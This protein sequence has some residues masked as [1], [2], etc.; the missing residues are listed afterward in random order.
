MEDVG[1]STAASC[2]ASAAASDDGAWIAAALI[3]LFPLVPLVYGLLLLWTSRDGV[4]TAKGGTRASSKA[5]AKGG[6]VIWPVVGSFLELRR[7]YHRLEDWYLGFFSDDVKTWKLRIP[8]PLSQ[9]LIATVDPV[10]VEYILTNIHKYG[11]VRQYV[12]MNN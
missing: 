4:V 3:A 11:K 9:T 2:A 10:N 6:P 12:G 7:N 1:L 8:F 5:K